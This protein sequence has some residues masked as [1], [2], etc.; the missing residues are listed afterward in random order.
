MPTT[1]STWSAPTASAAP[2]RS[3]PTARSPTPT[4]SSTGPAIALSLGGVMRNVV[5][6]PD[7]A[8]SVA[9]MVGIGVGIDYALFI[10]TRYRSG[11]ALGHDPEQ[12]TVGAIGTA[13]RA[14]LFA[15][16]TV[17][18]SVLGML[19]MGLPFLQGVAVGSAAAVL[20]A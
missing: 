12:A 15:G 10:V 18:I 9:A 5:D 16:T 2:V 1:W 7:W 17:I 11:L 3:P 14:V 4:S 8:P 13:G 6:V 19:L 20:I